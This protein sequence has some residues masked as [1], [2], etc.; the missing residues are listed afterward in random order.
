MKTL[1][2]LLAIMA[3]PLYAAEVGSPQDA[4][5]LVMNQYLQDGIF[6]KSVLSFPQPLAQGETVEGWHEEIAVPFDGYLVLIDDMALANWEHPCRWVFVGYDGRTEV[7]RLYTPPNALPRMS[8]EYTGVPQT[9]AGDGASAR[10]QFLDWFT[11]NPRPVDDP[12]NCYAWIISGG[13]NS[14]NNHI[15]YYGDVQFLYTTLVEDYGYLDDNIIVCFADGT[16][17]APDNSDGENSN[18]DLDD[19][20]DTDFNYDATYDGVESGYNDI[21]SMVGPSDYLIIMTTDHG[22]NGKNHDNPLVPP[23]VYLNLWNSETLDDDT[24]DGWIDNID[25]L[26]VNV[27][28]EQCFSGGFLEEV[29]PT[30]GGQPRTFASAANGYESSWAG[31]TYPEYDEWI[32]WW[33]GAMHGEVPPGGSYPGGALPEDPDTNLDGYVS[34]GEAQHWAK[35]WDSYAQSGQEHPQYDDD[36][37]SC[38]DDYYLGGAIEE[39]I[40]GEVSLPVLIDRGLMVTPNPVAT[41]ASASFSLSAGAAVSLEVFDVSGRRVAEMA[42]GELEQGGHSFLWDAASQPN[43][44]Y[45]M[46]LRAGE[47]AVTAKVVKTSL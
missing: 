19:D 36:P 8:V 41:T 2:V 1:S 6:G 37:D 11:P 30:T 27:I 24:F 44:V 47:S 34:Y 14:G 43:G 17:P 28:M 33:I 13:A 3:L 26:N 9:S 16:D 32:Y 25:A 45:L 29:I 40:E 4:A 46:V 35:E 38:G 23:E 12:E 42:R 22:G 7:V 10:Q 18:P 20:G 31:A 15:R 5:D 39:G 21:L